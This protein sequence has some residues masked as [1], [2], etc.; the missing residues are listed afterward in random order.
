MVA[1]SVALPVTD[2]DGSNR[3]GIDGCTQFY[4]LEAI[5]GELHGPLVA[6]AVHCM[7]NS[8]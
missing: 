4:Q 8:Y 5:A 6:L 1:A 3:V 7:K 2:I